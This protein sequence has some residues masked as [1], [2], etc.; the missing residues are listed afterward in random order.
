MRKLAART[1]LLFIGVVL[2]L[3]WLV[4]LPVAVLL[5]VHNLR[6]GFLEMIADWVEVLRFPC[7]MPHGR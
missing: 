7:E 2:L 1:C 4:F 6:S 3:L 5:G